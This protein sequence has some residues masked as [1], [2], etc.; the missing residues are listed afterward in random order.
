MTEQER[1]QIA[2]R[3]AEMTPEETF[4]LLSEVSGTLENL[5]SDDLGL[6]NDADVKQNGGYNVAELL[7]RISAIAQQAVVDL[8]LPIGRAG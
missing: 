6:M 4:T 7:F 2:D 1:S 3:V 5:V 8:D